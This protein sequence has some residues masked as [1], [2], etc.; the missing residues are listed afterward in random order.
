MKQ[1]AMTSTPSFTSRFTAACT[2]AGSS[3][4]TTLPSAPIRS[5]TSSRRRRS[6]RGTGLS[7][8][9]SK[10]SGV[11]MRPISSTSRKPRVVRSPVA[12]PFFCSTAFEP[13]VVP[14]TISLTDAGAMPVPRS[15]AASPDTTAR[16]GSSGVE[17]VL[18]TRSVPSGRVRT[19]SVKV[20]PMST[21]TRTPAGD[22]V[23]SGRP[24]RPAAALDGGQELGDVEVE[25]PGLLDVGRVAAGGEDHEAGMRDQLAHHEGRLHAGR[26]QIADHDQRGDAQRAEPRRHLR[27]RLALRHHL[28]GEVRAGLRVVLAGLARE[29]GEA[30]RVLGF[31]G[32]AGGERLEA[33]Q[34]VGLS[35]T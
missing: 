27:H 13:T 10:R 35:L 22:G 12:A 30:A 16:A 32:G 28:A 24:A 5:S 23:T 33:A 9:R 21:P 26:V 7:Q 4:C 14:C 25:E 8:V 19:I 1:M 15:R 3:G 17:D 18:L 31:E 34:P 29:L 11:R 2:L 6:T 20:P